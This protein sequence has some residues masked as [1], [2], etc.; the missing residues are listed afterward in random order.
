MSINNDVIC[1]FI[2]KYLL[3]YAHNKLCSIS[4]G[5]PIRLFYKGIHADRNLILQTASFNHHFVDDMSCADIIVEKTEM[6]KF[7][8]HCKRE[9]VHILLFSGLTTFK[10]KKY[11]L[12][13][14]NKFPDFHITTR[15][16]DRHQKITFILVHVP[17]CSADE[18]RLT[19][20]LVNTAYTQ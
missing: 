12:Q 7:V 5:Q 15:T 10:K 14:Q 3:R 6:C 13:L 1:M 8:P 2:A 20:A 9:N 11:L 16:L 4:P 18:A 19:S 17:P